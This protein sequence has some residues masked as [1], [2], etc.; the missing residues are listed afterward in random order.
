M[1]GEQSSLA[2]CLNTMLE[3]EGVLRNAETLLDQGETVQTILQDNLEHIQVLD[4]AGCELDA[5]LYYVNEDLPVLALL[6]DGGAVLITG[7][8]EYNVVIMDPKKGT[9]SK[10]GMNDAAEWLKK[11]GNNFVTYIRTE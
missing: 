4:L 2:V 6:S 3:Y 9:L 1:T 5:M 10:M 7:F 11:N 8:N